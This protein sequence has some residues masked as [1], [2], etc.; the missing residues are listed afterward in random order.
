M[1]VLPAIP[2]ADAL[3]NGI[4][5]TDESYSRRVPSNPVDFATWFSSRMVEEMQ[6]RARPSRSPSAWK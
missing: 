1:D 3:P 5:I 2:Y 6:E 4:S